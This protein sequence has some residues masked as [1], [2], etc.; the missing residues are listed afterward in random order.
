MT[1]K[2]KS[3]EQLL[4]NTIHLRIWK[5]KVN[6]LEMKENIFVYSMKILPKN[7]WP[8]IVAKWLCL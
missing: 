3:Q 8:F 7:F 4:H 2:Y 5:L 6:F 1:I